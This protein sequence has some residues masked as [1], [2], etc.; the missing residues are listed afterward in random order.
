VV[1]TRVQ[2]GTGLE[3][4]FFF[5]FFVFVEIFLIYKTNLATK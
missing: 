3:F 4:F 5:F 2:Q 1:S